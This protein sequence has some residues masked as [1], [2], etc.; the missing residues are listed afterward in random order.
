MVG[1]HLFNGIDGNNSRCGIFFF[2]FF[3]NNEMTHQV[4][5]RLLIEHTLNKSFQ[6]TDQMRGFNFSVRRF[7]GHK[8]AESRRNGSRFGFQ[9]IG[10]NHKAIVREKLGDQRFISFYL[11]KCRTN[12]R[13][14]ISSIFQLDDYQRN[15]VNKQNDIRPSVMVVFRSPRSSPSTRFETGIPSVINR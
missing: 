10:N 11:S 9:P 12:G 13:I 8:T 2:R 7:P 1:C 14:F 4:D 5:Q 15:A 3:K 6:L